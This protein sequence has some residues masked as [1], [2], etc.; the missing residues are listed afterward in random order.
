MFFTK[1]E[2]LCKNINKS[3]T[4]VGNELNIAK[5]TISYWRNSKKAIPKQDVLMKIADYF[6]VSVDYL[7]GNEKNEPSD[8]EKLILY[9]YHDPEEPHP[10]EK[11]VSLEN[12]KALNKLLKS[13]RD[14]SPEKIDAL[15]KVAEN[16][17]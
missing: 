14:L 8:I 13:A 2:E 16:M 17:K 5:T 6:G 3:T 12:I 7:L 9:A 15:I 11:E 4:A 10:V 1:F